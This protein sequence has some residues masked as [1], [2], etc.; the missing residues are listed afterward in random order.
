M[1]PRRRLQP[2][3]QASR[4]SVEA[5]RGEFSHRGCHPIDCAIRIAV[6][7]LQEALPAGRDAAQRCLRQSDVL[8][9]PGNPVDGVEIDI[10]THR[11]DDC[12]GA[13]LPTPH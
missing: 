9:Q 5:V 8:T 7:E 2:G 12:H 11:Q 4:R 3:M 10:G 1:L 13:S 6:D